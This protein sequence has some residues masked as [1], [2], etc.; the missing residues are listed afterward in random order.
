MTEKRTICKHCGKKHNRRKIDVM[1]ATYIP[2]AFCSKFCH[3]FY[4][5]NHG[6]VENL[7][8]FKVGHM[9]QM[10]KGMYEITEIKDNRLHVERVNESSH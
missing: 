7:D 10:Q 5:F 4:M 1:T 3:D 8:Q 6:I 9:I 2:N